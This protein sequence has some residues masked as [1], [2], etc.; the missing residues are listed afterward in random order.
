MTAAAAPVVVDIV[1]A[2]STQRFVLESGKTAY[3]NAWMSLISYNHASDSTKGGQVTPFT[4]AAGEIPIG[5]NVSPSG[6]TVNYSTA[7]A[8]LAGAT[9][10]DGSLDIGVN[11]APRIVKHVVVTGVAALTDANKPVYLDDDQTLSLTGGSDSLGVIVGYILAIESITTATCTVY[12]YGLEGIYQ[13]LI[14]ATT[15]P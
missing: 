13:Q 6:N 15:I 11:I 7:A 2:G 14:I 4:G 8:V 3:P 1:P 10:G 12:E 5:R 9:V